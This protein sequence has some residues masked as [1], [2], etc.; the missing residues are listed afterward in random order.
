MPTI[1]FVSPKGGVGKTTSAVLLASELALRRKAVA[2]IDADPNRPLG[3]WSKMPGCPSS[4][5]V[6]SL[7]SNPEESV[8]DAIDSASTTAPFVLVDLEGTA[9]MT[10]AY[11]ISRSDLVIIPMQGSQ[12]DATQA[13]RSLRL[14]A[15]QE[16]AFRRDIPHAVLITRTSAAIQPR[17]LRH[18]LDELRQNSVSVLET[19][20][21]EREA[22]KAVF[23][24]GGSVHTLQNAQVGGL[25]AARR[26]AE[27]YAAEVITVLRGR[28]KGAA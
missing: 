24:F 21:H 20:L 7:A 1:S 22:F 28:M 18:L 11:A 8:L 15:Q 13:A 9:N 10:V 12:L 3:A 4:V 26:N 25:E 6:V 23:S 14:V 19:Q 27:S 5:H 17:N 2:M 16:K